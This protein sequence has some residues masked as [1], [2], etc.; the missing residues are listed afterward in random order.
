MVSVWSCEGVWVSTQCD[1]L[2]PGKWAAAAACSAHCRKTE[3][4][5][6][7]GHS[8]GQKSF[9]TLVH[10]GMIANNVPCQSCSTIA[11]A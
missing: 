1:A 7:K 6:T 2:L 4:Q 8:T 11:N 5:Q 9:R 3:G 10:T